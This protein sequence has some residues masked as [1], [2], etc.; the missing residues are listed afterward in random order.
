MKNIF[1]GTREKKSPRR[2]LF[3]ESRSE[4]RQVIY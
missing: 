1:P 3:P 4:T 2:G